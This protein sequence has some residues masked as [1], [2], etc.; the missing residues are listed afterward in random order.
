M[1]FLRVSR[2]AGALCLLALSGLASAQT[3]AVGVGGASQPVSLPMIPLSPAADVGVFREKGGDTSL[4]AG[5]VFGETLRVR[6]AGDASKDQQHLLAAAGLGFD[7]GYALIGLSK[8]REAIAG[9]DRQV[10]Q[11]HG[12]FVEAALSA[13]AASILRAYV[14]AR[15]DKASSRYLATTVTQDSAVTVQDLLQVIR[16]GDSTRRR[17]TTV[18]TTTITTTTTEHSFQGG[19]RRRLGAGLDLLLRPTTVAHLG[20]NRQNL[21]LPGMTGQSHTQG[22]LGVTEY[23]PQARANVSLGLAVGAASQGRLALAGQVGL[24]ESPWMLD[25]RLWADTRGDRRQ[26]GAYAG[27]AYRWGA[28]SVYNPG[29]VPQ[30]ARQQ[31]DDRL[32]R[33]STLSDGVRGVAGLGEVAK[34]ESRSQVVVTERSVSERVTTRTRT[35][36][37]PPSPPPTN[38]DP[39]LVVPA[40]SGWA[41]LPSLVEVDIAPTAT[42]IGPINVGGLTDPNGRLISYS[43]TGLPIGVSIDSSTGV[44]SGTLT[45]FTSPSFPA[46]MTFIDISVT[47]QA[48][49]AGSSK[50]ISKT[51]T[52]RGNFTCPTGTSLQT[53]TGTCV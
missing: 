47:V 17:I 20:L 30:A 52:V 22:T 31:L 38:P 24:S 12:M 21:S 44:V 8:A 16:S 46:G 34:S 5:V 48:T 35:T 15:L 40:G 19:E 18:T 26:H 11:A 45:I 42:P 4:A 7:K 39:D 13:P 32:R 14:N 51:V 3:G 50:S 33:T 25:A 49:A 43:A 29:A 53:A 23:F 10:L 1:T 2:A 27:M 37:T 36:P 28:G 41:L 9:Y 6:L